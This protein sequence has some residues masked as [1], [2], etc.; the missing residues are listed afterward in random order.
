GD[1]ILLRNQAVEDQIRYQ[2]SSSVIN[3]SRCRSDESSLYSMEIRVGHAGRPL[4]KNHGK[5][6]LRFDVG[7]RYIVRLH[8]E[9]DFDVASAVY[10]DGLNVLNLPGNDATEAFFFIPK[11]GFI[12]IEGWRE[13]LDGFREFVIAEHNRSDVF[14]NGNAANVGFIAATFHRVWIEGNSP[15]E[16]EPVGKGALATSKGKRIQ[17]RVTLLPRCVGVMR[18]IVTI[19]Y[20]Y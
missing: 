18:D 3:G 14:R 5:P 15:P 10:V 4:S 17:Q 9:S 7:E 1:S 16:G 11:R 6:F 8:N 2:N 20:D 19:G 12:D 13:D